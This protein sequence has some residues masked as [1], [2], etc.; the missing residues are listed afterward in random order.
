MIASAEV[1]PE[2]LVEIELPPVPSVAMRVAALTR[3]MDASTRDIAEAL[4]YDPALAAR[5]LRVANS[6]MYC[7]ERQITALPMAV[8]AL[9]NENIYSLVFISAAADTFHG[10][11]KRSSLEVKLWEH[12]LAVALTA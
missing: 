10:K 8:N 1:D 11:G 6:A 5:I 2:S 4:G 3:D 12:S 7:F 9:G